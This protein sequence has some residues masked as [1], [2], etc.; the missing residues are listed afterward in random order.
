MAMF[1][2]ILT[3]IKCVVLVYKTAKLRINIDLFS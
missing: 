2:K 3:I 1:L